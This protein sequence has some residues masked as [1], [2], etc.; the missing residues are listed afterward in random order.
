M[1]LEIVQKCKV[2]ETFTSFEISRVNGNGRSVFVVLVL[3]VG[4]LNVEDLGNH[5]TEDD[6]VLLYTTICDPVVR[7]SLVKVVITS[8]KQKSEISV[9]VGDIENVEDID[10]TDGNSV[11]SARK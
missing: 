7:S 11:Q 8:A 1:I 4:D 2:V 3:E 9:A 5:L 6:S 10:D